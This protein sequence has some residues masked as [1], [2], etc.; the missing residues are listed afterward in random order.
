MQSLGRGMQQTQA[1]SAPWVERVR[2]VEP[3]L[4]SELSLYLSHRWSNEELGSKLT[5]YTCDDAQLPQ[6][7]VGKYCTQSNTN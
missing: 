5:E 2:L 1:R 3:G 6:L 7:V 4:E